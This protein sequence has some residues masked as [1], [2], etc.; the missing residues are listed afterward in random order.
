METL[1]I[2]KFLEKW[3]KGNGRRNGFSCFGE[4]IIISDATS[5]Q[6]WRKQTLPECT[7]P[8]TGVKCI[9]NCNKLGVYEVKM[10]HFIYLERALGF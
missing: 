10:A 2:G 3:V 5:E 4:N 7:L 9:K 1:P 8:L 6:T